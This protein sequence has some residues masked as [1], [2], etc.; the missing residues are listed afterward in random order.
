MA[1]DAS[2]NTSHVDVDGVTGNFS[3]P[4]SSQYTLD[5]LI[6]A[7]ERGTDQVRS[8]DSRAISG[9]D[10]T[11]NPASNG[12]VFTTG[13]TGADSYVEVSASLTWGLKEVER[14]RGFLAIS[15]AGDIT[16]ALETVTALRGEY[17]AMQNRLQ[18]TISNLMSASENTAAAIRIILAV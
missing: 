14:G 10:V 3:L 7:I 13:T 12:L 17:G 5:S 4:L 9:V 6:N 18:Y 8:E 11:Y 1:V 2:N 16:D 15:L